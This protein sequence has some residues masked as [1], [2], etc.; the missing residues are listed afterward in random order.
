[1]ELANALAKTH[2][3][4]L[5]LCRDR[6]D[7]T[8][9][10]ELWH[11]LSADVQVVQIPFKS[12]VHPSTFSCIR[13]IFTT[14]RR[15]KPDIIH[16]QECT[17]PLNLMFWLFRTC[18]MVATVHDVLPHP[19]PQKRQISSK[20]M[21]VIR[22]L[23][24][25]CYDSVIVHG[26]SLKDLFLSLFTKERSRV[27]VIAHGPLSSFD[28]GRAIH[29]AEEPAT[30]LFFGRIQHYKGLGYLIAAEPQ[31]SL[32]VPGF[33]VI[34]A[35]QGEDLAQYR[36]K[37]DENPRFEVHDRFIPN[38]EVP[39]F[40]RRA[41]LV[42]MPYLEASQSGIAAMAFAFEKPVVTTD[43]GSLAEMVEDGLTGTIVPPCDEKA[44][45][46]AIID[47]LG[48]KAKRNRAKENIKD[49]M[50]DRLNWDCIADNTS[51]VYRLASL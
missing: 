2:K 32:H 28:S 22:F 33:K 27:H 50:A 1:M 21:A 8:L 6:V 30:V 26:Q 36:D 17:N 12:M 43:V 7:S 42:V 5:I 39:V 29:V 49:V 51:E 23:R 48:D 14:L 11:R 3:V 25:K 18:P 10:S 4:C 20:A 34:I 46:S 37:L 47:M 45:A 44:L 15:F 41:A 24:E 35:G 13:M 9:G 19:G 38:D 31:V 40:F 16:L